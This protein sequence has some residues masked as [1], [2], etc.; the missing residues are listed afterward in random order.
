MYFKILKIKSLKNMNKLLNNC[1]ESLIDW[2]LKRS[3]LGR[4]RIGVIIIE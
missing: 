1:K 2:I 4:R 3:W